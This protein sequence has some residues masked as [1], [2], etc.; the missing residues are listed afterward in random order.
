MILG[1]YMAR[2]F[3]TTHSTPP[4]L[5]LTEQQLQEDSRL[6]LSFK[7]GSHAA[8]AALFKRYYDDLYYYGLKLVGQEVVVQEDIQNLFAELWERRTHLGDVDHVK[9]YLLLSLR[10]RLLRSIK[11]VRQLEAQHTELNAVT[12]FEISTEEL[13]IDGEWKREQLGQLQRE[14]AQLNSSQREI[15]YLR[16]YNNLD[17]RDI[18]DITGLK[19]QSVRNSMHKALKT[20]R[21]AFE[22]R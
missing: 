13:M 3:P 8:F 2:P 15:I 22:G 14:L 16:F 10:R 20:L 19:Y 17:Y 12:M 6:W 11:R 9:G 4:P 5:A 7:Q 18:A 21:S 1:R